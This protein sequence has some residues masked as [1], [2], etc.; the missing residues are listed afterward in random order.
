[1]RLN[2]P[3]ARRRERERG[4]GLI[5]VLVSVV[6]LSIGLL[7]AARRQ[8]EGMRFSQSAYHRSQAY[9]LA[10]DIIDRMRANGVGVRAGAYDGAVTAAGL[11]AP[12]CGGDGCSPDQIA[13]RDVAQWSAA[14]HPEGVAGAPVAALP[15]A[16]GIPARGRVRAV[17]ENAYTVTMS[18]AETVGGELREESLSLSFVG[19]G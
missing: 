7:A 16:P 13:R 10:S 3:G 14:L 9:F 15:S 1:M 4:V 18:W 12:D 17:G 5:E 11:D 2:G 8:V 19:Q 6:I